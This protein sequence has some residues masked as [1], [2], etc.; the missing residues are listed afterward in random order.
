MCLSFSH[1]AC[2]FIC[3]TEY[4][5]LNTFLIRAQHVKPQ[6]FYSI[7]GELLRKCQINTNIRLAKRISF[8]LQNVPFCKYTNYEEKSVEILKAEAE[9]SDVLT[10]TLTIGN[11]Q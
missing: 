1:I 5:N 7:F 3:G 9:A 2:L 10:R 8:W 4:N 6:L 11:F